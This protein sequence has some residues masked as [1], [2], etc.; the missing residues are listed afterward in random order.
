MSSDDG[1]PGV[2]FRIF[3][4]R[5]RATIDSD[6]AEKIRARMADIH[7]RVE[8]SVENEEVQ[9]IRTEVSALG[10]D[11][12]RRLDKVVTHKGTRSVLQRIDATITNIGTRVRR[13]V[14][15][16]ALIDRGNPE[17]E[18]SDD[19]SRTPGP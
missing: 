17:S 10:S 9:R 15:D 16:E 4:D 14:S 11:A 3:L 19:K 12:M 6:R 8:A 5:V 2:R 13:D 18:D 1:G 7:D